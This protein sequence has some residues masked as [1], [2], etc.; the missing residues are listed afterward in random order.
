[1]RLGVIL[2]TATTALAQRPPSAV[3]VASSRGF[4][5]QVHGPTGSE[6]LLAK[7]RDATDRAWQAEIV[8][9]GWAAPVDDGDGNFDIYIDETLEM[10]EAYTTDDGGSGKSLPSYMGLPS[11]LSSTLGS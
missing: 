5:F 11:Q 8:D 9:G 4:A 3:T 7:I 2:L 1:M 6:A 10:G